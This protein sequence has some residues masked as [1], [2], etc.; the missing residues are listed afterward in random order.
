MNQI[1]IHS[2][3]VSLVFRL[4]LIPISASA[5]PMQNLKYLALYFT[6]ESQQ[7]HAYQYLQSVFCQLNSYISFFAWV[8]IVLIYNSAVPSDFPKYSHVVLLSLNSALPSATRGWCP[9]VHM[10]IDQGMSSSRWNDRNRDRRSLPLS[11]FAFDSFRGKRSDDVVRPS[12]DVV[13]PQNT[14]WGVWSRGSWQVRL[15]HN[16]KLSHEDENG[17][18]RGYE[19]LSIV[20]YNDIDRLRIHEDLAPL[21]RSQD[22]ESRAP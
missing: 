20:P 9:V 6:Q 11:Q 2:Y 16:Q 15:R 5:P 1:L 17:I 18:Q 7:L 10:T 22:S 14:Y 13:D 19:I 3:D 8:H 12:I 21:C 4:I